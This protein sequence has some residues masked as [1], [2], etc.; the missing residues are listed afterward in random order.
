MRAKVMKLYETQSWIEENGSLYY[1]DYYKNAKS[2]ENYFKGNQTIEE[3]AILENIDEEKEQLNKKKLKPNRS[4][5]FKGAMKVG[6]KL[7]FSKR[8]AIVRDVGPRRQKAENNVF[9]FDFFKT[10]NALDTYN[11]DPEGSK[12][13]SGRSKSDGE[14][15]EESKIK[16]MAKRFT[17][18]NVTRRFS[19]RNEPFKE[20]N[21]VKSRKVITPRFSLKEI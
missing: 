7:N 8:M 20:E 2:L 1:D 6:E 14:K 17:E 9:L 10:G 16:N 13:D 12:S 18:P 21:L 15:I 4:F 5:E 19:L 3:D 11:N